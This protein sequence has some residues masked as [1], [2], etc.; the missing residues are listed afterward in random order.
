[1]SKNNFLVCIICVAFLVWGLLSGLTII[2]L[3]Q[4]LTECQ[5]ELDQYEAA[6]EKDMNDAY[7][8]KLATY[9]GGD[10]AQRAYN[11]RVALNIANE[12]VPIQEVVLK[13]LYEVEGL[14]SYEFEGIN[15]IQTENFDALALIYQYNVDTTNDSIKFINW[16]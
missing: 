13:Q 2:Q 10:S 15:Y 3:Q 14:N 11:M 1:M 6:A 12:D 7:L 4:D 5:I 9:Y 8:C 16:N